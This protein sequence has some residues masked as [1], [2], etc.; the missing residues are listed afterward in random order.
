M[1]RLQGADYHARKDRLKAIGY[2]VTKAGNICLYFKGGFKHYLN[3]E[4]KAAFRPNG[5]KVYGER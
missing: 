2:S 1:K 5:L 4:E 3:D